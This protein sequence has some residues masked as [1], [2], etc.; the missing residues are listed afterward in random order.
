MHASEDG[1]NMKFAIALPNYLE[2]LK[3]SCHLPLS[4]KTVLSPFGLSHQALEDDTVCIGMVCDYLQESFGDSE[5]IDPI[6]VGVA[7]WEL[8]HL[9]AGGFLDEA[10]FL[11]LRMVQETFNEGREFKIETK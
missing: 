4:L 10:A 5:Y 2:S 11:I 7:C 8:G 1:L 3:G 6:D 9:P